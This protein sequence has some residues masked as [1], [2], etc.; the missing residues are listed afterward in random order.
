M[1]VRLSNGREVAWNLRGYEV[2]LDDASGS[3]PHRR[4]RKILREAFPFDRILEEVPIP[5]TKLRADFLIPAAMTMVE[6]QGRQHTEHSAHLH[7]S[8]QSYLRSRRRDRRKVEFCELN[9][10][11][12]IELGDD[13]DDD[14]WRSILGA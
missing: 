2:D 7:G 14:E 4:A 3:G 5:G 13:C 9:D 1:R 12:L 11:T 10:I 8:Y 6:V